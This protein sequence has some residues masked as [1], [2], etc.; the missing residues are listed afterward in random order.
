MIIIVKRDDEHSCEIEYEMGSSLQE[1]IHKHGELAVF[2]NFQS[3]VKSMVRSKIR[4]LLLTKDK[5]TKEFSYTDA[6]IQE[7]MTAWLAPAEKRVRKSKKD[8]A[9][10][11]LL[12]LSDEER[13]EILENLE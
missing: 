4:A 2:N 7:I 6:Q 8:N 10:L 3:T 1:E 12:A 5:E 9:M 11:A 13:L